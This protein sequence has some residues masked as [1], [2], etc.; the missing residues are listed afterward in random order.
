MLM[1]CDA[2]GGTRAQ[3]KGRQSSVISS[4]GYGSNLGGSRC[5]SRQWEMEISFVLSGFLNRDENCRSDVWDNKLVLREEGENANPAGSG[6]TLF[7]G[8]CAVAHTG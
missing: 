4:L 5:A 2:V 7:L 6:T 3:V 1:W 8:W